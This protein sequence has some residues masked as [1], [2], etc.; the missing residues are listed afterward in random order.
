MAEEAVEASKWVAYDL[1]AQETE[2]R[3]VEELAEV[4]R[5]YYK[6]VW[7]ETLNLA[8]IPANSEWRQAGS[9]YYP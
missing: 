9:V 5:D 3:L 1:G 2:D 4:C 6:E 8:G 7:M